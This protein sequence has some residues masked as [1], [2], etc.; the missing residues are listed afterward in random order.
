VK[1]PLERC[2]RV[3]AFVV[4]TVITSGLLAEGVL[5]LV[6]ALNR[7][8]VP[9]IRRMSLELHHE[10]KARV[11]GVS[12]E[13]GDRRVPYATNS[14]AL[15]DR[16]ARTVRLDDGRR[17]VLV[18][19]DSFVE[20]IGVAWDDTFVARLQS[21]LGGGV[22]VL[23]GGVSSYAP[24]LED[25]K[26]RQLLAQGL[27]PEVVLVFLD[28]SDPV[29]ELVYV[30]DF[31]TFDHL[32]EPVDMARMDPYRHETVAGTLWRRL[33]TSSLLV[34]NLQQLLPAGRDPGPRPHPTGYAPAPAPRWTDLE[35]AKADWAKGGADWET[36]GRRAMGH[37]RADLERMARRAERHRFRLVAVAYPHPTHLRNPRQGQLLSRAWA[38]VAAAAGVELQDLSGDFAARPD[39][40][41]CFMPG[42]VHWN[43]EGHRFVAGAV[44]R[45]VFLPDPD[46]DPVPGPD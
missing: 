28:P 1:R 35:S 10:L 21:R 8:Q 29:D 45:R 14:L 11:D 6:P 37:L 15:R 7:S 46:P 32:G 41:S 22:E 12:L 36:W 25:L 43:E 16:S 24:I 44:H 4:W 23:N 42:D 31:A 20:G 30:E 9:L 2:A 38:E 13:W 26:L 33:E 40:R 39:W 17:R 3:A 27:R 18:L 19:G 5:R 34:W